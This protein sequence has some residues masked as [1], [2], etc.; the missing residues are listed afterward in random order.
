M[1]HPPC[2]LFL[3]YGFLSLLSFLPDNTCR[4]FSP[5][6]N[7][8]IFGDRAWVWFSTPQRATSRTEFRG[9]YALFCIAGIRRAAP[10]QPVLPQTILARSTDSL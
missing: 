6:K 4:P 2:V 7:A 3:F 1:I 5:L 8:S 9:E 10:W